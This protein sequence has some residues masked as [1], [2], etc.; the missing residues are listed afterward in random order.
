[1]TTATP[2]G[3]TPVGTMF[4]GALVPGLAVAGL[5]VALGAAVD[6]RPGAGG[7]LLGAAL[8][9]G[10]FALSLVVLGA[11]R[12]CDPVLT[13]LVALT[14]YATKIVA[15]AAGLVALEATGLLD[16]SLDRTA[17]GLSVVV[18]T[19]GWTVA[20]VVAAVKHRQPLYDLGEA[21]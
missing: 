12:R 11:T 4:R 15:L 6:G 16:G 13:M 1:M 7:A 18:C 19:V 21:A 2:L 17:F 14:F 8:V 20:E 9:A 5:C 3:R 10:S